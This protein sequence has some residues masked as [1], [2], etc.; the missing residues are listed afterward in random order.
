IQAEVLAE[1]HPDRLASQHELARAYQA[2]GQVKQAV[3]LMEYV[4]KIDQRV[5]RFDHPSRL[6][7]ESTLRS[8]RVVL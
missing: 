1:D 7:S 3:E 2:N 8:W 5:F 6:L 4:V